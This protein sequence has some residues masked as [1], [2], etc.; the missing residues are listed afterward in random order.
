M[1]HSTKLTDTRRHV[2]PGT[3]SYHKY[4]GPGRVLPSKSPLPYH[5]VLTTYGTVTADFRRGGGV[6]E[7]FHWHRVILDEG[8]CPKVV[9]CLPPK[10]TKKPARPLRSPA[11][12]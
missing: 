10:K 3:L 2:A 5:V 1:L 11:G 12:S 6:L 9:P 4:H 7:C 8:M